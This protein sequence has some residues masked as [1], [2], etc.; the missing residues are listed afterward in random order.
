MSVYRHSYLVEMQSGQEQ[1]QVDADTF[2]EVDGW[3]IFSRVPAKG[4]R[5]IEYWRARTDLVARMTTL[6]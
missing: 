2:T 5:A 1:R 3:L 6:P 4:G